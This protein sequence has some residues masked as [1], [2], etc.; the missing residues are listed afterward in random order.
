M[1]KLRQLHI[2][3]MPQLKQLTI[4]FEAGFN[5]ITGESGS[6][7]TSVIN[8]IK[9]LCGSYQM[10]SEPK[11]E[12]VIACHLSLSH[13]AIQNLGPLELSIPHL[14]FKAKNQELILRKQRRKQSRCFINDVPVTLK[15]FSRLANALF[16]V[17]SQHEGLNILKAPYQRRLLDSFL[18]NKQVLN[19]AVSSYRLTY[20]KALCLTQEVQKFEEW[21][22]QQEFWNFQAAKLNK[23]APSQQEYEELLSYCKEQQNQLNYRETLGH[24]ST[25]LNGNPDQ[26]SFVS[27]LKDSQQ[28][29]TEKGFASK[30]QDSLKKLLTEL[31]HVL[32]QSSY[33]TEVL[34][35]EYSE[36]TSRYEEAQ[37]RVAQ[38]QE[39]LRVLNCHSI[40]EL[41]AYQENLQ[42]NLN[43]FEI[44]KEKISKSIS[45]IGEQVIQCRDY[46]THLEKARKQAAKR[47][48]TIVNKS[49]K[50]LGIKHSIQFDFNPIPK[51]DFAL[52]SSLRRHSPEQQETMAA[53]ESFFNCY[54]E[55]GKEQPQIMLKVRQQL[56]PLAAIASGGEIS[57]IAL[58][59][60]NVLK[61]H[62][63][64]LI[65]DE[66]DS[67]VSG[68]IAEQVGQT[69]HE[70]ASNTQVLCISHLPQ[71]T[72][73][74]SQHYSL[75]QPPK[76]L[77]PL[78][79][80][81]RA[82]EIAKLISGKELTKTGLIHAEQLMKQAKKQLNSRAS[83]D[84][85]P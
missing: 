36:D 21:L 84:S 62:Y 10:S 67:G 68:K 65:M 41:I 23:L 42:D 81:E 44:L 79:S 3:N 73:F 57:R 38:Y 51:R 9:F 8:A 58:A 43:K 4:E 63:S 19:L 35:S 29:L 39:Q 72:A 17:I 28:A 31:S 61:E 77:K 85:Y 59:F 53:I 13:E 66:A 60:R 40:E 69:L 55:H 27:K 48:E 14:D 5:V 18:G 22:Q 33:E 74:A 47:A 56:Q 83:E 52:P 82:Q 45:E 12:V 46:Y 78:K 54:S 26:S 1:I 2:E 34:L 6:G 15:T 30:G 20:K 70:L 49:I 75:N 11:N 71:V 76:I 37:T 50:I 7:K 25:L 24:L 80:K 32:E 64:V 16:E